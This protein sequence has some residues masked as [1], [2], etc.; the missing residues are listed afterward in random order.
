MRGIF[1]YILT[2]IYVSGFG[3]Y[4]ELEKLEDLNEVTIAELH[5]AL[6]GSIAF[7]NNFGDENLNFYNS[8]NN[9]WNL[10]NGYGDVS[11]FNNGDAVIYNLS[12]KAIFLYKENIQTKI[13]DLADEVDHTNAVDRYGKINIYNDT[14]YIY[15]KNRI[16]ISDDYGASF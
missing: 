12:E 14:L 2:V 4:L 10:T 6:N 5:I 13:F 7:W 1:V 3:Q 16:H 9:I 11:F 15:F 8:D